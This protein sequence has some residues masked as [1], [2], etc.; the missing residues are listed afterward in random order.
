MLTRN[1]L[2]YG[3]DEALPERRA[4]RAGPLS[5]IYEAGDLRTIR[6]GAQEVLRRI[7]VAVRDRNWGT[8]A[9]QI[10][11][12]RIDVTSD[13]FRISYDTT[14]RRDNIEFL[15]RAQIRGESDGT[16]HFA[17]DGV[18]R[19]TFLRNRIGFCVLH[20]AMCAGARCRVKSVAGTVHDG[21]FPLWIEPDT[22]YQDIQSIEH[23]VQPDVWAKVLLEGEVFEME[24]QR[25]WIDAS[26]KTYCT[27]LRYPYPVEISEG[28][29]VSQSVTLQLNAS[30]DAT[31]LQAATCAP[32]QPELRFRV[33]SRSVGTLPRLGLGTASHGMMLSPREIERLRALHLSHLRVDLRLSQPKYF[34][35]FKRATDEARSLDVSLEAALFVTDNA[36]AEL[37]ALAIH[38]RHLQPSLGWWLIFHENEKT[39]E[40]SWVQIA[41]TKLAG[42]NAAIPI[43]AGTNAYFTELNRDRPNCE[44]LDFVSFSVTPQVHAFDNSS[45]VETLQALPV[46][47]ESARRFCEV[48]I[49]VSPITFKPRFNPDATGSPA[50]PLPCELSP[51]VDVRQMSLFGAGWT[52]GAVAALAHSRV[53]RMTFYETSGWRGVMETAAASPTP[54]P[55]APGQVFPLYHVLADVGEWDDAA[56]LESTSI[57]TLAFSGLALQRNGI[58][59]ILLANHTPM[60]Q[61]I[62]ILGV[63]TSMELRML[64]ETNVADAMIAPEEFRLRQPQIISGTNVG[65]VVKLRP[66]AIARLDT[67]THSTV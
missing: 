35:V 30:E 24:D 45:L 41:H 66:Y 51:E 27:P 5:L 43:G 13:S 25:N 12:E 28:T 10:G 44:A 16:L 48:P 21:F 20:P 57:D 2:L 4:L 7:Y 36:E 8:V 54:F 64:D 26:F 32:M 6:L 59:R 42:Y 9:A 15:W 49:V 62:E 56:L 37:D 18:A 34:D 60:E 33:G 47:V 11:N 52:L 14:H 1:V 23:E 67:A 19:S 29:S 58:T 46:T 65:I 22:P 55:F 38:L 63:G 61:T 17:M 53:S 39:T 50:Q 31:R 3:R 40:A